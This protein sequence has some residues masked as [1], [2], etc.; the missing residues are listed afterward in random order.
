[1]ADLYL[2]QN[3]LWFTPN[4]LTAEICRVAQDESNT[5]LEWV[6]HV[7]ESGA[8]RISG[9]FN[10]AFVL[11]QVFPEKSFLTIDIFSWQP[12]VDIQELSEGLIDLF[13]PQVVHAE[14]KL[15]AEHLN[16]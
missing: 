6:F 1:M 8:I 10:N 14:S 4:K 12:Q 15:R 11:M 5:N 9:E 2:C 3:E 16:N 13:A 7:L